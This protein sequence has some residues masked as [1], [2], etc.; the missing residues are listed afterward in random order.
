[1]KELTDRREES[2]ISGGIRA[3]RTADRALVDVD[4]LVDVLEPGDAIMESR[5]DARAVEVARER[6]MQDVLDERALSGTGDTR[7]GH[8]EAQRNLGGHV[9]EVV[10]ACVHD[11]D[12]AVG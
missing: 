4:D 2:R 3:R 7:D 1:G 6:P 10:L 12:H 9:A 11:A 5:N 8:E